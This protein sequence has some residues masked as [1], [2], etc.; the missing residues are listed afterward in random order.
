MLDYI[1]ALVSMLARRA[2]YNAKWRNNPTKKI[3]KYG[4]Y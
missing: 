1:Y 2:Y 4:F 3:N